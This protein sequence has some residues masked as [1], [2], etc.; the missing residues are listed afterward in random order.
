MHNK[1]GL[2]SHYLQPKQTFDG[3]SLVV[4]T[5]HAQGMYG[6]NVVPATSCM[7]SISNKPK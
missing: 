7:Y 1:T 2:S 4:V 5:G 3:D 6:L